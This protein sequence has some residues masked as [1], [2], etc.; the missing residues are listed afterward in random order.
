MPA[1]LA[2]ALAVRLVHLWQMHATPYWT[3]LMGDAREYDAWAQ[4]IAGGD[5]IGSGVYYQAPLYP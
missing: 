1:V 3:V 5:W 2:G 4:R